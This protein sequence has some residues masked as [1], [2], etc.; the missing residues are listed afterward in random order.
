MFQNFISMNLENI[1]I[2]IYIQMVRFNKVF[3][4]SHLHLRNCSRQH[5][6]SYRNIV[7]AF[8]YARDTYAR[9]TIA[10]HAP[11]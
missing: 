10:G 2:N 5:I 11:Y 4:N 1:A 3:F 9:V 6:I 8:V 7:C